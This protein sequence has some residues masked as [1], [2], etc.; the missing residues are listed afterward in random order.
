MSAPLHDLL[1]R[2]GTVV[3]N[4]V[5]PATVGSGPRA[6]AQMAAT[7]LR[8]IGRQL[9]LA[10]EHALADAAGRAA[11]AADLDGLVPSTTSRSL[12]AATDEFC[13]AQDARSLCGLVEA[14]YGARADLGDR[15]E[16]LR[17]RVRRTLREEIDRRMEYAA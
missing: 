12:R 8:R 10:P 4:D 17:A 11:L 5:G 14:I 15:F 6:Q 16:P 13:R 2:M 3:R 7:L 9:A 1:E